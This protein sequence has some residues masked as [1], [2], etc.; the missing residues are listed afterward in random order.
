MVATELTFNTINI[1]IIEIKNYS[2]SININ[3]SMLRTL[4]QSTMGGVSFLSPFVEWGMKDFS[5]NSIILE[6]L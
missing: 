5:K 3:Y 2:L 4:T 1:E 6:G